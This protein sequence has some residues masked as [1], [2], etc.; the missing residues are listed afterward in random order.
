MVVAIVPA[1]G[2]GT[3]LKASVP[4]QFLPLR[5]V[6]LIVRTLQ[7]VEQVPEIA[8][9]VVAIP[10][11]Y[12]AQLRHL[13]S[14]YQLRKVSRIIVGGA[15]RQ[16]SVAKALQTEE[17]RQAEYIVIHDAV[18]PLVP[19]WLFQRV[20]EAAQRYGAAVP[21]LPPTDTVK[22]VAADG[23]V[24]RTLQREQLRLIQT[25]QAFRLELLA[26]AYQAAAQQGWEG[27]DDAALVEA[28]GHPVAI[29]D[30]APENLK[31]THPLDFR[32]AESLLESMP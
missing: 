1:A 10:E 4:K 17:A 29:V 28:L 2:S 12:A 22:E 7:A 32:L 26:R 20:L 31:I 30:G 27:T 15:R 5:D 18:R 6:P 9:A 24:C 25:P 3:R 19:H 16:D 11:G 13:C 14:Q 23:T 8:A 21:G